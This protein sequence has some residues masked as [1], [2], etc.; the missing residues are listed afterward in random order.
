LNPVISEKKHW[1][2]GVVVLGAALRI[3]M[4]L[5]GKSLWGDE[6]FSIL[7]AQ[8]PAA[9]VLAGSV[10]D[11]HPPVFFLLLHTLIEWFGPQE[12]VFRLISLV[13]GIALVPLCFLIGKR[14]FG[15]ETGLTAAFCV[16]ISPYWLQN[17]HEIRGYA[18]FSFLITVSFYSLIRYWETPADRKWSVLYALAAVT[19]VYT[20]HYAWFWVIASWLLLLWK[21]THLKAL[22]ALT[23][24]ALPSFGIIFYQSFN[25][26][27]VFFGAEA[28]SILAAGDDA[29][30]RGGDLLAFYLRILFYDAHGG[31]VS[32]P[33]K[34]LSV[35][36][37]NGRECGR[38]FR[39]ARFR[40]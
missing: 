21:R 27:P 35:F 29:E 19:A 15:Q 18:L 34:K 12:W 22:L 7:L 6:F 32:G 10:A 9:Q 26:E 20:E 36:L 31:R 16:A 13:C 24:L 40:A 33:P 4:V 28:S 5:T 37:D 11:V 17:A 8:K 23:L 25:S 30:E 1:L 39:I 3:V 2:F 38:L 14:L